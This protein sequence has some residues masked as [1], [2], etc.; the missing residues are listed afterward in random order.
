[1]EIHRAAPATLGAGTLVHVSDLFVHEFQGDLLSNAPELKALSAFHI[2]ET[3]LAFLNP[4]KENDCI[5]L[6]AACH[7][8]SC[9]G[10]FG[11]AGGA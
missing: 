1:V 7:G 11:R 2:A 9:N 4:A 5:A 10:C 3:L 6:S 8:L